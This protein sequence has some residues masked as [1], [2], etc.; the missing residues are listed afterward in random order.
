MDISPPR[1]ET[2]DFSLPGKMR[3]ELHAFDRFFSGCYALARQ[4]NGNYRVEIWM[5]QMTKVLFT[6]EGVDV[7]MDEEASLLLLGLF[8]EGFIGEAEGLLRETGCWMQLDE[9]TYTRRSGL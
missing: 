7:C 1:V 8:R 4:E 9:L 2:S 5:R 3:Y 6:F